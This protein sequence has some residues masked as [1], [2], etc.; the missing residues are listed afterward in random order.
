MT[1][2]EWD[3]ISEVLKAKY[4][5]KANEYGHADLEI[6]GA[7]ML[8]MLNQDEDG[9]NKGEEMAVEF[10]LLGKIARAISAHQRG[11]RASDDTIEDI[12]IYG[13]MLYW[14]RDSHRCDIDAKQQAST[15]AENPRL[16]SYP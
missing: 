5:P 11:E 3:A 16:N 10:Y 15:A 12:A 13:I 2:E 8:A 1:N 9:I 14:L 7:S 6:M 4:V